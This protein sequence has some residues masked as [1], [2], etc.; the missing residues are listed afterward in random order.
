MT[1]ERP[2]VFA[3]ETPPGPYAYL[4][5]ARAGDHHGNGHVY[6]IDANGKKIASIWGTAAMKMGLAQLIIEASGP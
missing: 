1:P 6:I 2:V 5:T 4:T 3:V